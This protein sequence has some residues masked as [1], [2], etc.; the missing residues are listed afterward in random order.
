MKRSSDPVPTIRRR[1]LL[2][3]LPP[4]LAIL[5]AG[6]LIDFFASIVPV[7]GAYDQALI[8]SALAIAAH[9]S[10]SPEGHPVLSLPA[11]AVAV[12]KTDSFD[13]IYFRV[14]TRRGQY[15]AGDTGLPES[16]AAA[17]GDP[18]RTDGRF[19]GAPV[20]LVTLHT[21][22][23]GGPVNVTVAETLHKRQLTRASTLTRELAV[24][25]AELALV[26]VTLWFGVRFALRPLSAIREQIATRSPR[27]LDPLPLA[28]VPLEVRSI[29]ESLNRLFATVDEASEA[30]RRFLQSA[31][32]QLRTPLAGIQAQ[33]ELMAGEEPEEL[34][35]RRLAQ[36]LD[37]VRRLT[38]TTQQ[39]LMLARS[40]EGANL[41][42]GMAPV[43]LEGVVQTVV[44]ER[45]ATADLAKL[46][47]GAG[48]Q[49]ATVNGVRWLL[50]EA[51]GNLVNNAIA[52]TPAGG[53]ITVACGIDNAAP[54]LEVVDSG[55]GI[56]VE[57][58]ER[59]LQRF[60]RGSNARG[61][62]SGLGLAIVVEVAQ[63]HG[64]GV[65]I[66]AAPGGQGTRVRLQFVAPTA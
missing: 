43:E 9:V 38:H 19:R 29:V 52:H 3:L 35:R 42:W 40:E 39:L 2:L 4:A 66:D 14:S 15:I 60:F 22:S 31:A 56:P 26:L 37:G 49:T 57:E 55:V 62:G 53:S 61:L 10:L 47:L 1:L 44:G 18:A 8:D 59:V 36:I 46:D 48:L 41:R 21:D 24:D 64:A 16:T 25:F 33:L 12:L 51:L 13:S 27:A 17:V 20:R 5:L 7:E 58:R 45:L 30:Q 11:A 54:F 50:V 32:H 6:T 63:L 65:S 28:P 23:A 34:R